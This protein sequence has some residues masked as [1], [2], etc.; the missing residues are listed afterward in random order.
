MSTIQSTSFVAGGSNNHT[1]G[2]NNKT[3]RRIP[4]PLAGT[5]VP[6]LSMRQMEKLYLSGNKVALQIIHMSSMEREEQS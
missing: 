3:L 6:T 4:R 1:E 5:P 2:R